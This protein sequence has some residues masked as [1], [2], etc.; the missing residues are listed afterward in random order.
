MN[1]KKLGRKSGLLYLAYENEVENAQEVEVD[2]F[3]WFPRREK[4]KG[5][6]FLS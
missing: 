5:E 4:Y 2:C 6:K 1:E 3:S